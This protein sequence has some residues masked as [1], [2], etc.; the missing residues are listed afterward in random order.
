MKF[1]KPSYE[2]MQ[3]PDGE[4]VL[5]LLEEAART[6][7]KSEGHINSGKRC[8][9]CGD[10]TVPECPTCNGT[11]WEKEPSSYK[12][13]RKLLRIGHLSVIEHCSIT[14]K[15]VVNRG[16]THELVRHRLA[17][18]SQESTR[19]CNYSKEKHGGGL[20]II[21][22]SHRSPDRVLVDVRDNDDNLVSLRWADGDNTETAIEQRRRLWQETLQEVERTYLKLLELGEKPQEARDI[23]PIGL[24]TEI[25]TTANLREWRHIFWLRAINERAHP[26]IREVMLPLLAELQQRIPLIFDDVTEAHTA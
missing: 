16:V 4:E 23:L 11:G 17:S 8:T 7:Y 22:P 3:C 25:V 12:L 6:C 9:T 15:F 14:V 18:Y 26:Q 1:I 5:R 20:N 24:K 13:I 10:W 21:E 19:Y 2:I